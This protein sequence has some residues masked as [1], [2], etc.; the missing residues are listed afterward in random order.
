LLRSIILKESNDEEPTRAPCASRNAFSYSGFCAT[1][2]P[3]HYEV[4][5]RSEKLGQL[6]ERALAP[7]SA[8]HNRMEFFHRE[9]LED[10]TDTSQTD[11]SQEVNR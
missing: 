10:F 3:E 1:K 7:F 5:V 4:Q 9:R 6:N 11:T 8:G 2:S